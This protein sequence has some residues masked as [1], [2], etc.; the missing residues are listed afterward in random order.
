M[1]V[2]DEGQNQDQR[3]DHQQTGGFQGVDLRRAVMFGGRVFGRSWIRLSFW[4]RRWHGNIVAL[5]DDG[6]P[7]KI[8]GAAG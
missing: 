5:E 6:G 3:R 4:T 8:F 7:Q 1:P 2:A